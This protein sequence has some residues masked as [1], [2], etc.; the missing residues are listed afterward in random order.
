M[1]ETLARHK[2]NIQMIVASDLRV[3]CVVDLKQG[4]VA[5]RA[6]HKAYGLGKKKK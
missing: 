4:E 6:L 3:S 2:I 5:L 1:F